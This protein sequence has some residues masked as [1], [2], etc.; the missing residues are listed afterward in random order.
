MNPPYDPID[1]TGVVIDGLDIGVVVADICAQ[2]YAV[3]ENLLPADKVELIRTA[4]EVARKLQRF[5]G[6]CPFGNGVDGRD[7]LEALHDGVVVHPDAHIAEYWRG[8]D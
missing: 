5:V 1:Q 4:R 2:G 7:P 6:Y 8:R 3:V